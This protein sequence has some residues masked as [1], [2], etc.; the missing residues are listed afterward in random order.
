MEPQTISSI[1]RIAVLIL[2][3]LIIELCAFH[4]R[5]ST[6]LFQNRMTLTMDDDIAVRARNVPN[7]MTEYEDVP[8][9]EPAVIDVPNLAE[10]MED[11]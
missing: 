10:E 1:V 2:F 9:K 4:L 3:P 5:R 6:D 8:E 7:Y 11:T